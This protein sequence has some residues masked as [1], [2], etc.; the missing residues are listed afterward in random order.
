[1][2][3]WG[4]VQRRL[5]HRGGQ[6]KDIG[7]YGRITWYFV[8]YIL[9][10]RSQMAPRIR[11]MIAD[12]A[13]NAEVVVLRSRRAARSYLASASV[14]ASARP[15]PLPPVRASLVLSPSPGQRRCSDL[16]GPD[17]PAASVE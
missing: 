6:H 5:C 2:C 8:R 12:H 10:Y 14:E 17:E 9:G 7:V 1:M 16:T 15:E 3:L 11:Q 13:G 4:I